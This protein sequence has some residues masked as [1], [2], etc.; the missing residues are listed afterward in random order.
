LITP[1]AGH[2]AGLASDNTLYKQ[3]EV[4]VYRAQEKSLS[5]WHLTSPILL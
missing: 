5:Q 4:T 1:S 3:T 2:V